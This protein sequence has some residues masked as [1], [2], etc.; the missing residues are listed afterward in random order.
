MP[1]PKRDPVMLTDAKVRALR[2][3]PAGE[4]HQGDL[5]VPGFAVRVRPSGTRVYVLFKRR[6]GET[7]PTKI[8][9]GRIDVISLADARQR[10]REETAAVRRGVDVNA[11]KRRQAEV[12]AAERQRALAVEAN[13]GYPAGS[14]G[15][16]AEAFIR[17]ECGALA[18]GAEVEAVIRRSLLPAWGRRPLDG[19]RRRDLT[20]LLDPVVAAGRTQAAHKLREIAIR[21]VNWA[22]DRGELETNFLASPS[23]GRRRSG[24]LRRSRR[25]RVLSSDEIRAV[26]AACDRVAKP[27]GDIVRLLLILGQRR[28][29]I[30]GMEWRELDL[31]QSLWII[32]P[33][34]YKTELE[35][36]VPLPAIAVDLLRH[37]PKID[38]VYV[39]STVPGTR[40]SGFS[41]SMAR[42]RPLA[43]I[44]D[45]RLHDLR[46]TV[47]TG[48]SGL[49]V[50][51][52]HRIGSD[53][54]ERVLGHVIG[55]V[56]G[57]YDRYQYLDEKRDALDRWA[58]QL[59]D[60]VEPPPANVVELRAAAG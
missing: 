26:W 12:R 31:E 37:V 35:H 22:V 13:T 15:E 7:K 56:R 3:D 50:D 36:A 19:L 39:F 33:A 48:L 18:R 5:A 1:K 14:F 25:D 2:P 47:R 9:I 6:P 57:I 4:Y 16:L 28:E 45:W 49:R 55:G 51:A 21:I 27:F 43:G 44:A 53:I 60:V 54:A 11:E 32:P 23:R 24:L 29:E 58:N 40:F 17:V 52:T 42:L 38:D 30:A 10:A 20:A 34:R 46:R 8:T 41:K 59:R